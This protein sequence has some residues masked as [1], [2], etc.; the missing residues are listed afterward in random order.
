MGTKTSLVIRA[1]SLGSV[2]PSYR[3]TATYIALVHL[4][5]ESGADRSRLKLINVSSVKGYKGWRNFREFL[6][7]ALR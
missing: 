6:F 1:A 5:R 2:T 4:L 7:H 3:R